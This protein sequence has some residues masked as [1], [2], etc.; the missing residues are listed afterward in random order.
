[1]LIVH[2]LAGILLDMDSLDPDRLGLAFRGLDLDLPLADDRMIKLRDLI[3][4][5]KI[6]VEI[7][8]PVETRPGIYLRLRA[9]C[10]CGPP[11]GRIRG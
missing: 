3:A 1:M 4:L 6:G 5:R 7:I 11:G 8:L 9:P 2:Q 10:R